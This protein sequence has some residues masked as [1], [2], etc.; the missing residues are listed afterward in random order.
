MPWCEEC[1]KY[2]APSAVGVDGACPG[3]GR[4][5]EP[6][7]VTPRTLN[8]HKLAAGRDADDEDIRAPWHFRLLMVLAVLYLAWRIIDAFWVA[9]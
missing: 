8:L 5:V 3:C 9:G 6:A 4:P 2:H 7:M 1:A